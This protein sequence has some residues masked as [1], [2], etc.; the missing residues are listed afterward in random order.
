MS[1][2][3]PDPKK[4]CIQ[5]Q[6]ANPTAQEGAFIMKHSCIVCLKLFILVLSPELSKWRVG[7]L[8]LDTGVLND[9]SV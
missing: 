3:G 5:Y 6:A 2:C 4:P 8:N 7:T 1:R 9:V